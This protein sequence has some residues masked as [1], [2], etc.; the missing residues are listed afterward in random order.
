ML[1]TRPEADCRRERGEIE[2]VEK[3]RKSEGRMVRDLDL[4]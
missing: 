3:G 1:R 2:G 4:N